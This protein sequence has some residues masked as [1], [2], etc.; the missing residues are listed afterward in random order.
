MVDLKDSGSFS[1]QEGELRCT[2]VLEGRVGCKVDGI[3][4]IGAKE[5][6]EVSSVKEVICDVIAT[7]VALVFVVAL[8]WKNFVT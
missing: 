3:S 1:I 6:G 4:W 2:V 8:K 7:A 5:E